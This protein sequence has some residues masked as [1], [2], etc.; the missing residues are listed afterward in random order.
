MNEEFFIYFRLR[1]PVLN[2]KRLVKVEEKRKSKSKEM[3]IYC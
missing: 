2:R 3:I 1:C